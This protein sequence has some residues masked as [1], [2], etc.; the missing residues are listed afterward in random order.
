MRK[1]FGIDPSIH[2]KNKDKGQSVIYI[3]KADV[4]R[5][6]QNLRDE[7]HPSMLYKIGL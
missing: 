3:K 5:I 1:N 4:K 6:R 2:V 7:M